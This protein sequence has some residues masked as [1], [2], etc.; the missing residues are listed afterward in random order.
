MAVEKPSSVQPPVAETIG[1]VWV[2]LP[3]GS[4]VPRRADEVIKR[5][6]PPASVPDAANRK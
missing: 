1:V 6:A 3:N 5:P 4:L 2:R